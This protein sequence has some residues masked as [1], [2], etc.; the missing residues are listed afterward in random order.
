MA[1]DF[2]V[3]SADTTLGWRVARRISY[4]RGETMVS[5]G[6]MHRVEDQFGRHIGYQMGGRKQPSDNDLPSLASSASITAHECEANAGVLGKSVTATM[7]EHKRVHR[8]H[9]RSGKLLP[10]EDFIE[11]AQG[12]VAAYIAT[13]NRDGDR[14]VRIYPKGPACSRPQ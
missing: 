1:R 3:Y 8:L 9:P 13:A 4:Q 2:P 14:A 10:A 11:R 12:K 7:S 6:R 5:A